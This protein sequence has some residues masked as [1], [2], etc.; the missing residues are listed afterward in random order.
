MTNV[1]INISVNGEIRLLLITY[2]QHD[3]FCLEVSG[4]ILAI[5]SCEV[6]PHSTRH[7]VERNLLAGEAKFVGNGVTARGGATAA[8]RAF[9]NTRAVREQQRRS[10][11][12]R[13]KDWSVFDVDVGMPAN[14]RK[15]RIPV[16]VT[17]R[18]CSV[19]IIG[20]TCKICGRD[21]KCESD[22]TLHKRWRHNKAIE[23]IIESLNLNNNNYFQ[24]IGQKCDI[25]DVYFVNIADLKIH[26]RLIHKHRRRKK[27]RKETV[28]VTFKLQGVT[29]LDI[30]LDRKYLKVQQSLEYSADA[31]TQTPNWFEKHS[32]DYAEN[33]DLFLRNPV[34][35]DSHVE[36]GIWPHRTNRYI[37]GF[38]S[39]KDVECSTN[40]VGRSLTEILN[41]PHKN[42]IISNDS[43][44][45]YEGSHD[46]TSNEHTNVLLEN[47][48]IHDKENSQRIDNAYSKER[49]K[50][51]VN[52]QNEILD[53]SKEF[54]ICQSIKSEQI[55]PSISKQN[56]WSSKNCSDSI[57]RSNKVAEYKSIVELTSS[58]I[59]PVEIDNKNNF[60]STKKHTPLSRD[61]GRKN[62]SLKAD[63]DIDDDV[64]EVLRI[65]RGNTQ[66]DINHES[67]NRTEREILVQNSTELYMLAVQGKSTMYPKKCNT[68]FTTN[69]LE[70]SGYL[71]F[72]KITESSYQ[73][74]ANAFNKKL[75][76][77][78]EDLQHYG[79]RCYE[80]LSEINSN[81]EEYDAV[82]N[83]DFLNP[84]MQAAETQYTN[85]LRT[86]DN[87]AVILD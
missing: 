46:S 38:A 12:A 75:G 29:I 37:V 58:I 50:R 80:N 62:E 22:V 10:L 23:P 28:H 55:V 14:K 3:V 7:E 65:T 9:G 19:V 51:K 48:T 32:D 87:E 39:T 82:Y 18:Q 83:Q 69:V 57:R 30:N 49:E 1:Y 33:I 17:L 36:Y 15:F 35:N 25:C 31:D 63:L 2:T 78:F 45:E 84:W 34:V 77:Y 81:L 11:S 43:Y 64:Q 72:T 70:T 26:K 44:K 79:I 73:F 5:P 74:L 66:S 4:H 20:S 8:S 68:G 54:P 76:I 86:N 24:G 52:Y 61:N 27:L 67:P 56:S 40:I 13:K 85:G 60:G 71:P 42:T 59:D 53:N 6:A 47:F 21:F 16:G 41:V